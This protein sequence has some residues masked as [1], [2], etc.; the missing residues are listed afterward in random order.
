MFYWLACLCQLL[1][2]ICAKRSLNFM[3]KKLQST[4]HCV[5]I[6]YYL[7]NHVTEK[8]KQTKLY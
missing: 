4:Y 7:L 3:H 5:I 2:T 8:Q 6:L 1:T